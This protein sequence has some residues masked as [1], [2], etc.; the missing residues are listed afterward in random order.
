[1]QLLKPCV[2]LWASLLILMPSGAHAAVMLK[3]SMSTDIK[4]VFCIGK[5]GD[6]LPVADGV[7]KRSS[8]S[9]PAGRFSEHSCAPLPGFEVGSVASRW[10]TGCRVA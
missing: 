10:G 7:P 5:N 4:S 1:M 3:N 8:R 6:K 9:V 2:V